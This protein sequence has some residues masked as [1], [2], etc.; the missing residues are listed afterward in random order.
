MRQG[1]GFQPSFFVFEEALYEVKAMVCS[2]ISIYFDIS[3][4]ILLTD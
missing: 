3:Y 2:L 1:D 4:Y